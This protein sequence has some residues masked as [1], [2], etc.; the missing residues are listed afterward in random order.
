MR[1]RLLDDI[2]NVRTAR[3][4]ERE[5][6]RNANEEGV[7]G[8]EE[9][10]TMNEFNPY[11]SPTANTSQVPVRVAPTPRSEVSNNNNGLWAFTDADAAGNEQHAMLHSIPDQL[12]TMVRHRVYV[13]LSF[14]L[15]E[16][17]D[18]IRLERDIKSTKSLTKPI[19]IIDDSNFINEKFLSH[20]QFTQAYQ[21]FIRCMEECMEPGSTLPDAWAEHFNRCLQDPRMAADFKVYLYMD[22]KMRQQLV[23]IPFA[24]IVGSQKYIDAFALAEREVNEEKMTEMVESAVRNRLGS[25]YRPNAPKESHR[26]HPY[27]GGTSS[28][29]DS[30]R[31]SG[32][33]AGNTGNTPSDSFRGRTSRDYKPRICLRCGVMDSHISLQCDASSMHK[34]SD[35]KPN[36]SVKDRKLFYDSDSMPVCF[37]FN[38][39]GACPSDHPKHPPH[40]CTLCL[41]TFHGAVQCT[42]L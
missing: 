39:H 4:L 17:M 36:I 33:T 34:H 19:R 24:P 29:T 5:A 30:F 40:R 27:H 15:V 6:R 32:S 35:R 18:R 41:A 23:K 13:P 9:L 26:Y 11:L 21:N 14:Y 31:A 8:D 28:G 7:E 42:R 3:N 20:H 10:M 22:I 25:N 37:K 12:L 1:T 16:S 38:L 2:N